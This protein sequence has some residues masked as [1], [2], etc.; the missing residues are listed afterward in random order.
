V[1]SGTGNAGALVEVYRADREVGNS[2]LPIAFIGDVTVDGSGHWTLN[3]SGLATGD[4][5]TALQIRPDDNTSVLGANV[6]VTR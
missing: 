2:G 6:R 3:V 5:V 1:I 4:H